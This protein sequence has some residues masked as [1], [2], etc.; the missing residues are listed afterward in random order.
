VLDE[1]AAR[2]HTERLYRILD[3]RRSEIDE[4]EKY[5]EGEQPL[6]FAS[7]KWAE[8]HKGRYAGFSDNWCGVVANAPAER[9]RLL[10]FT[11]PDDSAAAKSL[12][13]VWKRNDGE[14]QSAQGFH[15]AIVARRSFVRVWG[16]PAT[17][18]ATMDFLHPSQALVEFDQSRRRRRFGIEAW[19]DGELE[20]AHLYDNEALYKFQ[21]PQGH[22]VTEQRTPAGVIVVESAIRHAGDDGGWLPYQDDADDTWP[23]PN[24]MRKVPLVELANRPRLGRSPVS[25]IAG[26]KAMQDA[27]N[28]L[29][30]YL[31]G[32]ADH[33]SL[34][35]RV[36]T[37]QDAPKVPILDENGQKV[38]E[39]EVSIKELEK[40]RLLWLTG[41][42]AKISQW[43]A[44]RLDVFTDVIKVAVGHIAAQTRTPAHYLVSTSD[45]VP[46]TGYEL[47]E[48][49][50]VSKVE[51]EQLFF[52][53]DLRE[54]FE[55]LAL[56][57]DDTAL[58]AAARA[59]H[60]DWHD[61]TIRNEAQRADALQ[62]KRTMGYP[63]RYL[64]ELE[65]L[66]KTEIDRVMEMV[67]QERTD[68]T[69]AAVARD[70]ANFTGE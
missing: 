57:G 24:P 17:D 3:S 15:T 63:L 65:G 4:L 54:V 45:N 40:G 20:Y 43:D 1:N 25:D 61:A 39:R 64:L 46:S 28:L 22:R 23:I 16:D 7:P 12:M 10:D 59:G 31:F 9:L 49:G 30:A 35:A 2:R 38:G 56:A 69:F 66:P 19:V 14:L 51:Q 55:L 36:V 58:A 50:L 53:S 37:G 62:K 29:W 33:A 44:A 13:E 6:V 32:A 52:G 27:I 26:T 60:V 8:F 48:S 47:A 70:V 42:D 41:K 5:A 68:P 18:E 21:R 67:Q 34:P 11:V